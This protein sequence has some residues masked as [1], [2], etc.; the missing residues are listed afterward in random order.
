MPKKTIA[1]LKK[2]PDKVF[3]AYIRKRDSVSGLEQPPER[4]RVAG[5]SP[6]SV[7]VTL[8]PTKDWGVPDRPRDFQRLTLGNE[9]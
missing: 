3:A 2:D 8:F 6:A 1:Q 9:G 5:S 7:S 4:A